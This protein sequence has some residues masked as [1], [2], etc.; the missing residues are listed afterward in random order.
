MSTACTGKNA[1]NPAAENPVF[2]E[3]GAFSADSAFAYVARQVDFGPRVP[4]SSAHDEC[5][6]WIIEQLQ[7]FGADT[8]FSLRSETTAWNGTRLPVRNIMARFNV[9]SPSRILLAA[10]YDTR[11]WA[12]QDDDPQAREQPFDGANDGASGVGVILEIARNLGLDKPEIGVDILFTDVED[13]GVSSGVA[14]SDDSWCLGARHFAENLPYSASTLPRYGILLDM[15]G[16]RGARFPRE[17]LSLQVAPTAT[18]RVWDMAGRLG[19]R[20][21]FPMKIGGAVTDDHIPLSQAGILT[22]DI[23]ESANPETGSF[24]PTWHTRGDNLQNIDPA[25]LSD[26]GRVVLNVIYNEK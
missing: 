14:H 5:A 21:R 26:V 23:I 19:L 16:G 15:V 6:D 17:Y 24:P 20:E 9:H 8:V 4:G 11:P 12:D 7:A 1:N 2:N 10:H 13:Y 22:T 25:T 18:A 3:R